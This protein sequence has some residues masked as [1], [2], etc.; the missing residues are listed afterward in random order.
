MTT[1]QIAIAASIASVLSAEW[2][3]DSDISED[4]PET[5]RS[6][7]SYV[8]SARPQLEAFTVDGV[9]VLAYSRHDAVAKANGLY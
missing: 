3:S 5:E 2:L 9:T 1:S 6:P 4:C 8:Q 7:I